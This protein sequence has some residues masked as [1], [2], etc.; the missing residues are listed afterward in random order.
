MGE[1]TYGDELV[2]LGVLAVGG[3]NADQGLLAVEGLADLV[4]ALHESYTACT[5]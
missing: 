2:V 1:R 5:V 3:Q 4:Q